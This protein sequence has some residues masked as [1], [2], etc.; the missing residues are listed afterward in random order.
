MPSTIG[1]EV[2][3]Q[4]WADMGLNHSSASGLTLGLGLSLPLSCFL[5]DNIS[6]HLIGLLEGF[7]EVMHDACH[8]VVTL[9]TVAFIL[10]LIIFI[11]PF[12]HFKDFSV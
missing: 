4:R 1:R 8:T 2:D 7:S 9:I 11:N 5:R 10:L 6:T 3:G 12:F